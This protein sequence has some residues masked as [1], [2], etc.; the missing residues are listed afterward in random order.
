MN[1]NIINYTLYFYD[2][3]EKSDKINIIY[4]TI[5]CKLEGE[6]LIFNREGKLISKSFY[7]NGI[8]HGIKTE[9]DISIYQNNTTIKA[10]K[11]EQIFENG[12]EIST[13]IIL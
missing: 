7:K 6:Y 4:T 9:Y 11:Y 12:I 3:S 10:K 8:L 5:N 2:K 13:N 1:D